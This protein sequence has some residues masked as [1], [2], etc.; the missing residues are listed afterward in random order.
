MPK[1]EK[2]QKQANG[3]FQLS[4]EVVCRADEFCTFY[5][6]VFDIEYTSCNSLTQ[7]HSPTDRFSGT[8]R[9]IIISAPL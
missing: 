1:G 8:N 7:T 3:H 9:C 5:M 4:K 2:R 6:Y